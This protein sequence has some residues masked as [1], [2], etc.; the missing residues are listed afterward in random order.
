[1]HSN[2]YTKRQCNSNGRRQSQIP[3]NADTQDT[4]YCQISKALGMRGVC[5]AWKAS[6]HTSTTLEDIY[7]RTDYLHTI[8]QSND[9]IISMQPIVK[10]PS[11]LWSVG[12]WSSDTRMRSLAAS[13]RISATDRRDIAHAV[14][15]SPVGLSR[16]RMV[17]DFTSR[18][19]E[20]LGLVS[21]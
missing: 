9:H 12:M 13:C 20:P 3:W 10:P 2:I 4:N 8:E 5:K 1:M 15:V 7:L 19:V 16:R 18:R 21:L 14:C 6:H 11:I 17:G